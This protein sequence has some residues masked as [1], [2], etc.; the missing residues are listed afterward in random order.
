MSRTTA[1]SPKTAKKRVCVGLSVK[2][3]KLS[4]TEGGFDRMI[5]LSLAYLPPLSAP[6]VARVQCVG[7]AKP[8]NH[9]KVKFAVLGSM[10]DQA[11][12]QRHVSLIEKE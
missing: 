10:Q 8:G 12:Q 1:K 5:Q 11:C 6:D 9:C 3:E 7:T 2:K 4:N